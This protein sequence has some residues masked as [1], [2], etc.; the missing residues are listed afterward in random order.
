MQALEGSPTTQ[1]PAQWAR[2]A[3]PA[4]GRCRPFLTQVVGS[5]L[6]PFSSNSSLPLAGLGWGKFKEALTAES[7]EQRPRGTRVHPVCQEWLVEGHRDS[8]QVCC[9]PWPWLSSQ[10]PGRR[11]LGEITPIPRCPEKDHFLSIHH[12]HVL[13]GPLTPTKQSAPEP[14]EL[15]REPRGARH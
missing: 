9:V 10:L 12:H 14:M 4:Q 1:R 13:W 15:H 2:Q 6:A 11:R 7:G 5:R 8:I 3:L